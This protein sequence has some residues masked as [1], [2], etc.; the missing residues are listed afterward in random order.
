MKTRDKSS[1]IYNQEKKIRVAEIIIRI[2]DLEKV[3]DSKFPECK[4]EF[5]DVEIFNDKFDNEL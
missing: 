1:E 4:L 5:D 3:I 2:I